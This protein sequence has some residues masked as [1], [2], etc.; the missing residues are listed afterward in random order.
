[1]WGVGNSGGQGAVASLPDLDPFR[2][3]AKATPEWRAVDRS[4][5]KSPIGLVHSL[6]KLR[7]VGDLF[8]LWRGPRAYLASARTGLKIFLGFLRRDFLDHAFNP[9]LAMKGVPVKRQG[10]TRIA[11]HLAALAAFVIRE[12]DETSLIT[13]FQQHDAPGHAPIRRR[14]RERHGFNVRLRGLHGLIEPPFELDDRVGGDLAFVEG[15]RD[16]F[17]A[18][19]RYLLRYVFHLFSR[20]LS[21]AEDYKAPRRPG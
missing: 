14:G 6:F 10:H 8:A 15:L 2:V 13:T 18:H 4:I 16:V 5:F 3:D 7:S 19:L 20:R 11:H 21:G 17:A 1:G 12:E 9:D